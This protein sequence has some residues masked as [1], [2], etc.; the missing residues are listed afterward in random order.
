ME[1]LTGPDGAEEAQAEL[2]RRIA[3]GDIQAMATFYDQTATPLFSVAVRILGDPSEAEEVI[4]DVFMQIWEKAGVF[5]PLLGSA[6]HWAISIARHRSIDRLRSRQRRTRLIEE[7]NNNT[8]ASNPLV[9][10]GERRALNTD[11]VAGI[12]SAVS[13]LPAEQRVA[14]EMAFFEGKTHHEIAEVLKEPLGTIKARIRRGMLR[15][16]DGLQAYV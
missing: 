14:I 8:G 2:L 16:R 4:Q 5:D 11:E 10:E 13:R 1:N 7:L 15:L 12:H 6:F 3:T 9:S